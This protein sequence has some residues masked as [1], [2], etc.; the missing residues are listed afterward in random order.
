MSLGYGD[1]YFTG[2]NFDNLRRESALST[3]SSCACRW[4]AYPLATSRNTACKTR[5]LTLLCPPSYLM[6]VW[7][8]L[9]YKLWLVTTTFSF[10]SSQDCFFN[11]KILARLCNTTF[12]V[13]KPHQ[14]TKMVACYLWAPNRIPQTLNHKLGILKRNAWTL[15]R[16]T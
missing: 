2:S 13:S 9:C 4:A 5:V 12:Q 15:N 7:H 6:S 3:R 10:L 1:R 11:S 8:S 16:K 14:S